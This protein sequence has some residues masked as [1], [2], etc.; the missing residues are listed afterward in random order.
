MSR[1]YSYLL[2][3]SVTTGC[4]WQ[5]KASGADWPQWQGPA[6]NAMSAERGLLQEWP[7]GGPPLAWKAVDIGSGYGGV[8]VANGRIFSIS[9]RGADEVVWALSETDGKPVWSTRLGPAL[10]EGMPQ[11]SEGPGCTPTVDGDR[12]YAIGAGGSL[13]CLQTSDGKVVWQRNL[14]SDFGG[15]L[16]VWRYNESPLIDG[17]KL[18]CT[19][20]APDATLISLNKLNG[21]VIW[22]SVVTEDAGGERGRGRRGGGGGGNSSAAYASAIVADIVGVRQYVQFTAMALVGVAAADGKLLWKYPRPANNTRINC[23]SPVFADGLVFA[24][25]AYGAGGG[26]AKI[27]KGEN[28]ELR[29]DEVYFTSNMQNHHGG[30]IVH[31]GALYGAAGGNEG[32]F[33]VCLNFADGEV[34]WRERR[35]PKGSLLFADGRL[36][37]RAEGGTVL[38]I[39]PSR[40]KFVEKGRFEQPDRTGQPAWTHPIIANGKLYIRDQG[41]LYCYDISL[42]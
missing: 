2:A 18:I 6:R 36:Y 17:E 22:K 41:T 26:A 33:L 8:S 11:G 38:L 24:A 29:A 14:V 12:L 27:T 13:A 34:L 30:M 25:S 40:E 32:G 28:G 39:E 9:N 42:K 21:E 3:F 7:Q 23:S 31:E 20:G 1:L 16:P 15:R 4:V 10:R 35:A 5:S 37:L 19:P